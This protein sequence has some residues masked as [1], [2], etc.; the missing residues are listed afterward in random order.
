MVD[1]AVAEVDGAAVVE[2]LAALAAEALVA[3]ALA[4]HGKMLFK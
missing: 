3:V 2:D 4:D 1:T